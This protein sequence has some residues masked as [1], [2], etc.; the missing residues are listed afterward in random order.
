M[1]IPPREAKLSEACKES[2]A[3]TCNLHG[4]L[5]QLPNIILATS[6]AEIGS[7]RHRPHQQTWSS[8]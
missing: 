2:E 8:S 6:A 7:S 1:A 4:H 3:R 5:L